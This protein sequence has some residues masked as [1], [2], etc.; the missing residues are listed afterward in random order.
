[1]EEGR[2]GTYVVLHLGDLRALLSFRAKGVA[3]LDRLC[4]LGEGGE[5]LVVDTL[6]DEDT[7]SGAACL[8]VVPAKVD[9][10]DS[11]KE[12]CNAKG[13]QGGDV[14]DPVA[15]PTDSR[16]DVS[17]V[18]DDIRALPSKLQRHLLQITLRRPLHNLPPHKCTPRKRHLIDL[19]MRRDRVPD[20]LS[21]P[22]NDVDHTGGESD[23]FD[24]IAAAE[25]GEGSELGGLH[26][27]DVACCESRTD[28]PGPHE[29]GEVPGD[30]LA[31]DTDGFVPGVGEF[32]FVGFDLLAHVYYMRVG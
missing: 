16:V 13:T 31:D 28:L 26:D 7:R 4:L 11:K 17:I 8:A 18:E 14:L 19:H 3:Y 10:S 2:R 30:D 12:R 1:M 20:S 15:R 24:E 23:L 5:K 21:V 27:D 32:A 9:V 29:E 6:L 25:G 22:R